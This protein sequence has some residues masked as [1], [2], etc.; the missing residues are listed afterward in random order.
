[1]WG[2]GGG[3]GG[4]CSEAGLS[5]LVILGVQKANYKCVPHAHWVLGN[6]PAFWT[7]TNLSP[8]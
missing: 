4:G 3:G 1:V 6:K 7:I 5:F 2:E 8:H